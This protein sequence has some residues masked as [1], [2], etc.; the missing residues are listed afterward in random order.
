[1]SVMTVSSNFCVDV[2]MELTPPPSACVHLSLTLVPREDVI[3]GWLLQNQPIDWPSSP[4]PQLASLFRMCCLHLLAGNLSSNFALLKP[5][6]FLLSWH[7]AL[8]RS[9]N[10]SSCQG[11]F[12]NVTIQY[13]NTIQCIHDQG[14]QVYLQSCMHIYTQVYASILALCI[15]YLFADLF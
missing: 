11:N 8:R 14:L 6:E 5:I 12:V 3:N 10:G 15:V 7:C 13:T 4:L 2:H 9:L 1:M